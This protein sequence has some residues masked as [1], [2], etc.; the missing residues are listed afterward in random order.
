[1][2]EKMM[3][4][5]EKQVS[6]WRIIIATILDLITSFFL[7]GYIVGW[8]TGDLTEGGFELSG[9]P[10]LVLFLLIILYFV[11]GGKYL[12]GTLWQRL[13]GTT[14]KQMQSGK[15]ETEGDT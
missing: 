15:R 8:I 14:R 2:K 3:A 11:V 12:G 5:E 13:L 6:T 4:H 9:M 7:L 1:V 10:A